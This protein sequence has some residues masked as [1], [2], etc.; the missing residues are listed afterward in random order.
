MI[1]LYTHL[2][3]PRVN[4]SFEL[5]FKTVLKIDYEVTTDIDYY[6]AYV[7]HKLAYTSH[8]E[9]F[10]LH[11]KSHSLL[12]ENDIKTFTP[13]AVKE[14]N[15]LP[16]FFESSQTSI[17]PFD[18][19]ATVFYFA[20][21]Y[22]EYQ[23]SELDKHQRFQAE[24]SLFYKHNILQIPYLNILIHEFAKKLTEYYPTIIPPKSAYTYLSTIDIDNAY[25]FAHKGFKRNAGGALLDILSGNIQQLTQ[26]VKSN[27]N[28]T[29]DPY[30]TF[31]II[32]TIHQTNHKALQYFVLI[33]DYAKYDKNPSHTNK[34]F[35][36]LLKKL[37]KN[38]AVGLHP[39]YVTY[40][41]PEKI[42][43]EKKRLEYIIE[44]P[45]T[46]ARC[47]FLRVNLPNT[48]R[49]F[50]EIGIT[51][52]YSMI[53]ASASGFRTGLCTP[54]LWFDLQKN[55]TT[56]LTIHPS[57]V[58]EGTLRDYNNL[59]PYEAELIIQKLQTTIKHYGGE[60]VTVWHNDSFVKEQQHWI[61]VYKNMMKA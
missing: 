28:D 21:R 25:A 17:T 10:K 35:Q 44:K 5:V 60:C 19:F 58:M 37:S 36:V 39:S 33:G 34:G 54:H 31:D 42:Y 7:G 4:Y 8:I 51:D 45:V 32:D 50:M 2:I 43:T 20:T 13:S 55:E 57:T 14:V 56:H 26:R 24:H 18:I 46:Q 3:T 59:S 9:T 61:E 1:L 27:W 30:N 29:K 52:D 22:E 38:Y 16:I 23:P 15:D 48:Y 49:T 6:N 11:L 40:D 12:F 53:Y 47:H 41:A